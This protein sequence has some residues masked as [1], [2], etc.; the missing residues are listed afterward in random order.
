MKKNLLQ[1]AVDGAILATSSYGCHNRAPFRE[2]YPVQDGHWMD[3]KTRVPKMTAAKH[4][5]SRDCK[6]TL[7][8]LGRKDQACTGCKW[9]KE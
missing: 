2:I 7:S 1:N 6:Y 8:D 5:L 4:V 3:G 9:R